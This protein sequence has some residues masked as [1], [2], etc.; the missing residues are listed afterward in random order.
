MLLATFLVSSLTAIVS[1]VVPALRA[2]ACRPPTVLKDEALNASGG[3]H[4]SR[5]SGGLVVAQIALS[6]LLL[7]C[8]G[9]FVRSLQKAQQADLG[10]DPNHVFLATYDLDPDGL[11]RQNGT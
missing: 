11:H 3:L 5:L 4:K 1:G 10:F 2:S 8:A 9:L 7:A 6:L